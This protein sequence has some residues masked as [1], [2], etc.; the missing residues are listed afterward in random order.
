[1]NME[2]AIVRHHEIIELL[3]ATQVRDENGNMTDLYEK[4]K[5]YANQ[6]DISINE[7]YQSSVAG[8]KPTKSFNIYSFEYRGEDALIHN[9]EK[10]Q[11][12]RVSTR[13]DKCNLVCEND[14]GNKGV[15]T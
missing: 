2:V 6:F 4:R 15:V 5:V 1:M 9:G 10:Y 8:M 7:F 13:G 3:T 11:I 12:I 14:I